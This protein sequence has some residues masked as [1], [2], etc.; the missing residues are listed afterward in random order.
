MT[1]TQQ[2][3]ALNIEEFRA[4]VTRAAREPLLARIAELE[5]VADMAIKRI[6]ELESQLSA[7]GAGGVE[8]LRKQ[9]AVPQGWKLVQIELL[10]RIQESL[11]SYLSDHGWSQ[12]DMD[13]ADALDGL[14]AA[15]PKPPACNQSMQPEL[16]TYSAQARNKKGIEQ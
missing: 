7:I 16:A 10:E 15:A 5:D 2:P 4:K 12:S 6:A 14:L 13:A 8:P 1:T 3:E 11:G 9:A